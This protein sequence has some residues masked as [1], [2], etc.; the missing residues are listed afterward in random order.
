MKQLQTHMSS[1][2]AYYESELYI[3]IRE[4]RAFRRCR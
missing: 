1:G 3:L 2:A 4:G